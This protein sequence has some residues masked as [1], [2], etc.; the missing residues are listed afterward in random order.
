ML[1]KLKDIEYKYEDLQARLSA[2][3]TYGDPTLVARL[4][5]EEKELAPLVETYRAWKKRRTT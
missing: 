2:P 4:N 5:R 3:E 1:D